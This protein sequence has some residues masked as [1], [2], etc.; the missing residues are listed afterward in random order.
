MDF[1]ELLRAAGADEELIALAERWFAGET[2]EATDDDPNPTREWAEGDP[3]TDEE[4]DQ[5]VE[6]LRALGQSDDV[7]TDTII[8]AADVV[9]E[10]G[11]EDANREAAAEADQAARAAA[12]AALTGEGETDTDATD[13]DADPDADPDAEGGEGGEDGGE[14]GDPPADGGEGADADATPEA[15]AAAGGRQR[16][17]LGRLART[18]PRNAAP[19]APESEAAAQGTRITFA[20]GLE[21]Y[22]PGQDRI[23]DRPVTLADVDEAITER[24]DA[25][26]GSGSVPKGTKEKIRVARIHGNFPEDRRLVDDAGRFIGSADASDRIA[27][28][29]QAGRDAGL[30][31][32]AAGG[33]CAPPTPIYG[34]DVFGTTVR[35][36]RDT[37]LTSFNATRGRVVSLSPPRLSQVLPSVGI[38]TQQ[39]DIDAVEDPDVRK[40]TMRVVCNAALESEVQ[41]IYASLLWGEMLGRTFSEWT[42]AWSRL[43]LVRH[44]QVAELELFAA[45]QALATPVSDE[46]TTISATRDLLNLLARGAWGFRSRNREVRRYPMRVVLPDVV[47][48]IVVEDLANTLQAASIEESLA[49]AEQRLDQALAARRLNVTWSP[50]LS[51]AGA[52]GDA[53]ELANYPTEL[54]YMI[55]PEGWAIHLDNGTLDVGLMRDSTLVAAN[56]VK[57]FVETFEGVHR[58]GAR[59]DA[60]TGNLTLCPSGAVYGTVD[61]TGRCAAYT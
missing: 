51:L 35:P 53:T 60:I 36:I 6:G 33:F 52:Q 27:A 5:L 61:P 48:D 13:S 31:R 15:V 41:G 26:S 14:G 23:G 34:V 25:F 9:R 3:M 17:R 37:A 57:T 19:A 21:R 18:R 8:A 58:I 46:P 49:M 30:N 2:P 38:W 29:F 56:D 42:S 12:I 4:L 24:V 44:A 55:Y 11:I 50:D 7:P 59:S 22:Q 40:T 20:A 10:L 39:D 16:T 54:P 1:I 43:S 47:R 28:V 32:V 45:M